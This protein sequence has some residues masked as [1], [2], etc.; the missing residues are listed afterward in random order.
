M[1][2]HREQPLKGLC[3]GIR[4]WIREQPSANL[5]SIKLPIT[6]DY[7]Q[8]KR[9]IEANVQGNFIKSHSSKSAA[10][11]AQAADFT[12]R[13]VTDT[14]WSHRN[15]STIK[16]TISEHPGA[17]TQRRCTE[18]KQDDSFQVI[19]PRLPCLCIYTS[20]EHLGALVSCASAANCSLLIVA[21]APHILSPP[22]PP[23]NSKSSRELS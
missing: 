11:A 3:R 14:W 23:N 2:L 5:F 6:V 19:S 20:S 9:Y 1:L 18:Q 4:P 10:W 13:G 21:L 17:N 22:H 15:L 12:L 7:T 8:F 16:L